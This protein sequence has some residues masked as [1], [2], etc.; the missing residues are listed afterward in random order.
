MLRR[1]KEPVLDEMTQRLADSDTV[2]V[3]D[4]RGLTVAELSELRAKLREHGATLHV[5][6]NTLATI[7]AERSGRRAMVELF[8]GPTAVTFTGDDLVGAAKALTDFARTHKAFEVR[9]G[10]MQNQIIDVAS[11]KAL[12]TLPSREMLIAQVVGTMAAPMTGLVTVLQGT[13]SGFV[14]VLSQ[15]VEQKEAAA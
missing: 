11:V 8:S 14:R 13:V 4:Y 1:D 6:K 9:G 5:L 10:F 15:V 12:A 3:A 7:A 2:F